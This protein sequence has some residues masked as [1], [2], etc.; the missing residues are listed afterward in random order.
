[1]LL[2]F[3]LQLLLHHS[4]LKSKIK[5]ILPKINLKKNKKLSLAYFNI[6]INY[7][8]SDINVFDWLC[9]IKNDNFYGSHFSQSGPGSIE[10]QSVDSVSTAGDQKRR[11]SAGSSK[12]FFCL[13]KSTCWEN[14]HD[15]SSS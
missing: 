13:Y 4:L 1:M 9:Q 12:S 6:L 15:F 7:H 2:E 14:S 8:I 5:K 10:L 11:Y 3:S